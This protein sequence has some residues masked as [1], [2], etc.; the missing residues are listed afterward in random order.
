MVKILKNYING[1]WTE[2]NSDKLI[3]VI[4]PADGKLLYH[5]GRKKMLKLQLK[6]HKRH[7]LPGGIHHLSAVFSTCFI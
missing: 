4:N 5:Q 2:S 6:K 3:E 7:G 1:I